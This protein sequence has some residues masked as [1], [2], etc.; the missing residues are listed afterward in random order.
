MCLLAVI[1]LLPLSVFAGANHL[2]TPVSVSCSVVHGWPV[3]PNGF[4]FG[5]V[6]GVGVD[7]HNR[8][9]VV[10]RGEHPIMYFDGDSGKLLGSWGDGMFGRP[11]GLC[12]DRQDNIW[13]TD[14]KRHV[15]HKFNKTGELLMTVGAKDVPGLDGT[16]FNRPTDVAI[17]PNGE[18]YV[19]D[20]YGNR[21]V[22]KFSP[23]GQFLLDWGTAGDQPGQFETPHGITVDSR[24]RILVADRSNLRVQIFDGNGKFLGQWKSADLGRPWDVFA[25]PDGLIYVVD[26]GDLKPNPPDRGRILKL[27]L[28]GKILE[29]FSSF[30]RA[31]GQIYWGHSITVAPNR[32]IYVTDILGM[33]VQKFTP[34]ERCGARGRMAK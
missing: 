30:G 29:K 7:S 4:A 17:G 16:H 11:H 13:V 2:C 31:D 10:H 5:E 25:A 28:D 6:S 23:S 14:D 15:V 3:L 26:G 33:R 9:F 8:I 19:T 34:T 22:A 20:G 1:A 12:V 27:S 18:F 21:R 24:G 32:D